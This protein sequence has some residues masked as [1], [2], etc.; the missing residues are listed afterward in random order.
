MIAA[1]ILTTGDELLRG[2]VV[3]TNAA[4]LAT[5]L[6]QLGAQLCRVVTVGDAL[7]ALTGAL[8]E[9][10]PRCQLLL[11]SGGL[12]PTA[13]DR[14]TEAVARVAS[15]LPLELHAEA[16]DAMRARFARGN[17]PFTPNNEKQAYLP[18][19]AT[20]LPNAH[21]TAPGF[22]LR[23]GGC[24][25]VCLPGV[26]HELKGI[27]EE[28]VV[29]RLTAEL[30][31]APALVH[32][33]NVFGLGESQLDH[34][35]TDLLQLCDPGGCQVTLHYRTSFP[36]NRVLLVVCPGEGGEPEAR[37]VMERL[38]AEARA[39]LGRHVFGV[40]EQSF[41]E[42][43][44]G[45]LRRCG[46]SLALAE[47]CTGGQA[48]DLLTSAAGSSE[49]FSLGVV[50]YS[51]EF[52]QRLL[53][54]P[55]QVLADHGAVSREC[56]EAMAL[57]VRALAGAT[58]GVAI[59]GVAGPS[60]GTPDKPVGTVHFALAA[61]DGRVRH[62]HRVFPFDRLRVKRLS[63]YTALALTLHEC[64]GEAS[65]SGDLFEG[66]WAPRASEAGR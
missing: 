13:D 20:L 5:R 16:L 64:R 38:S 2:D 44:V 42:A 30:A 46:A 45:A 32:S 17:Y 63:A 60:G 12:G 58:Y 56:V 18:R 9:A 34:R 6:K 52:K 36:E 3:N 4:W 31:L 39:R 50:A 24:L 8:A 33:L 41:P 62:L 11:V 66:R 57:G 21:G 43:V 27:F 19:G 14:T 10:L 40:D 25:V 37:A 35:L 48:A 54:V 49:V 59:S 55:Q 22:M 7:P 15:N 47:S 51:N 26:P 28:E 53:G 23:V 29:P 61:P 65:L 1:E